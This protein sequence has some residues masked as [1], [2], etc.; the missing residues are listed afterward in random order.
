MLD[1]S[2]CGGSSPARQE[3]CSRR[4]QCARFLAFRDWDQYAGIDHYRGMSV[5][6]MPEGECEHFM[7]VSASMLWGE[8]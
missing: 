8:P 7:A 5:F 4:E 3:I 2:R 6:A 1:V